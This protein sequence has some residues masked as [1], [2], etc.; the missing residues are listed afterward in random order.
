MPFHLLSVL[1]QNPQRECGWANW[2][3]LVYF[4]LFLLCLFFVAKS[5]GLWTINR[6]SQNWFLTFFMILSPSLP[7]PHTTN[8]PWLLQLS[9]LS[10]MFSA[11]AEKIRDISHRSL[12]I[13]G[14]CIIFSWILGERVPFPVCRASFQIAFFKGTQICAQNPGI[15]PT[16]FR[17]LY[18][19]LWCG[20]K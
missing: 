12:T 19:F 2:G 17:P 8:T 9:F 5:L 6:L 3:D 16:Y 4:Q 14:N 11:Y 7:L 15:Y 10:L 1:L 18:Y 20:I 13:I